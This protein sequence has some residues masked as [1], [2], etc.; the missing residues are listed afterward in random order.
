MASKRTELHK[1]LCDILGSK[2]VYFN[3]PEGF[4]LRYPCIVYNLSRVDRRSANNRAYLLF[5]SYTITLIERDADSKLYESILKEPMCSFS[6]RFVS[7]NLYH[8]VLSMYY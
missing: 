3:P 7:E 2:N 6:N 4:K 8:T 5:D 1:K